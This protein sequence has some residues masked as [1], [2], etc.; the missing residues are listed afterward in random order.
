M[1]KQVVWAAMLALGI[2]GSVQAEEVTI[3][4]ST[5]VEAN[6]FLPHQA[7]LEEATGLKLNVVGNGS[8]NGI[9]SLDSGAAQIGMISSNLESTLKKV[10]VADRAAEFTGEKIGDTIAT[11]AVHASNPVKKLTGE[12]VVG[13]LKGEITNWSAVGGNDAPIVVVTE[14]A[15]GGLRG[16][17]EKKVLGKESIK[18]GRELANGSQIAQV[19]AQM[20]VAFATIAQAIL[21]K[22]SGLSKIE[23]DADVVQPLILVIKGDRTEAFDKLVEASK[24]VLK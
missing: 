19:T 24:E 15:G 23:S 8:S 6:L 16:T 4:G 20:P 3:H 9:K 17:I 11:F 1:R 18:A 13:I 2:V 5:T 10:G 14:R 22:S 12:Q 21:K 7:A